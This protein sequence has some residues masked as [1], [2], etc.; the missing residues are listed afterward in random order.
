MPE[1]NWVWSPQGAV[2]MH[3][4]ERWGVVQLSIGPP[5]NRPR[6]LSRTAMT[7]SN[8]RCGASTT[9]NAQTGA[10]HGRYARDL[11]LLNVG[12]I[13]VEGLDFRPTV[14]GDGVAV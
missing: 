1:D 6:R 12:D 10:A 7:G 2:N 4:P 14:A 5:T 9:G 3:M 13:H 11:T 8:G